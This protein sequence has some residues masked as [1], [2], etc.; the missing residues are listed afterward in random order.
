MYSPSFRIWRNSVNCDRKFIYFYIFLQTRQ[1][2]GI[3]ILVSIIYG[4]TMIICLYF[5][6]HACRC[7]DDN[8]DDEYMDID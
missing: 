1:L 3:I 4:V 8:W 7:I 5:D 2:G 6:P